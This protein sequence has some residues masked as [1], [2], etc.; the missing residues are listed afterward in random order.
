MGDACQFRA[1]FISPQQLI[2]MESLQIPHPSIPLTIVIL[3]R[4]AWEPGRG[5]GEGSA[6]SLWKAGY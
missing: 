6:S 4:V 3:N 5:S 2:S 1:V